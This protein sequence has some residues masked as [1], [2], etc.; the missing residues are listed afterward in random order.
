MQLTFEESLARAAEGQRVMQYQFD[1]QLILPYNIDEVSLLFRT[2]DRLMEFCQ[3][4]EVQGVERFNTALD[5]MDRQDAMENFQVHFEFMRLPG[6]DWRIEAM[7]YGG[8][9]APL[10]EQQLKNR[11]DGCVMHA[12]FKAEDEAALTKAHDNLLA[13]HLAPQ[14][15]YRNSY[16]AF[17]YWGPW[18]GIWIKPRVNLRDSSVAEKTSG[19]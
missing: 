2:E 17:S 1:T 6:A 8:G 18:M 10:H 11:G 3:W 14:A 12:S 15:L 7:C 13:A 9:P 16:G 5:R 4:A 19:G